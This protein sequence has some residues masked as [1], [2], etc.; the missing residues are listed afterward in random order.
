MKKCKST[1][2]GGL[3]ID[4]ITKESISPDGSRKPLKQKELTEMKKREK[5]MGCK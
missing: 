1:Y 3:Q 5:V 4:H 2:Y